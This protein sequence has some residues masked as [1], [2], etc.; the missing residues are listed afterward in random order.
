MPL[1]TKQGQAVLY[2]H[3]PK[4][5][6]TSVEHFFIG[7]GFAADYM[8]TGGPKSLNQFRRCPPQHMHAEQILA[9][10]RP[11]RCGYVFAT[12]REPLARIVSEYRMRAR[13]HAEFPRLPAWWEQSVKRYLEI[14]TISR[15]TS[16]RR[17]SS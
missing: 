15:T 14:P 2:I 17:C 9:V 1:F 12:V 7:N 5:G 13:G 10:L 16:A 3:V 11:S 4:T 8:D 6:G